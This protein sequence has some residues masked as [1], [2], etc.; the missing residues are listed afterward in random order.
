MV[1]LVA[2]KLGIGLMSGYMNIREKS[3]IAEI[4]DC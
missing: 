3:Q 2:Q 1:N 4:N